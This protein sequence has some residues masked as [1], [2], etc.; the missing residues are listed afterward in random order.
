MENM[1]GFKLRLAQNF[2][3]SC[4]MGELRGYGKSVVLQVDVII[5]YQTRFA[6]QEAHLRK[7]VP[8]LRKF[9]VQ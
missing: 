9:R 6:R 7:E 1:C 8:L 2:S 5:F 4:L 3:K